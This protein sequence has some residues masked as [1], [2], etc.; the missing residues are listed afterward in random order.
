LGCERI[1]LKRS[2]I[3]LYEL[4]RVKLDK[5]IAAAMGLQRDGDEIHLPRG[6]ARLGTHSPCAGFRFPVY[7]TVQSDREGLAHTVN[8]VLAR[9]TTPFIM[10]APTRGFASSD[11][12]ARLAARGATF[13]A[14][15]EILHTNGGV[16]F[17]LTRPLDQVLT[18]FHAA[19]LPDRDETPALPFF[20]TPPDGHLPAP[21]ALLPVAFDLSLDCRSVP[22]LAHLAQIH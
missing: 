12:E 1:R 11:M 17:Q 10:M 2:D 8:D 4:D 18:Q 15:D 3:V 21:G 13:L 6:T 7:L 16:G 9:D 20:P 5:G 19:N 22:R 14:L